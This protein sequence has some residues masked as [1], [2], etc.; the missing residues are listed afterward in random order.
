[1]ASRSFIQFTY[2][3]RIADGNRSANTLCNELSSIIGYLDIISPSVRA[4]AL[5]CTFS[6]LLNQRDFCILTRS[7]NMIK[8]AKYGFRFPETPS[9]KNL[10]TVVYNSY[11][12]DSQVRKCLESG[13]E[14][15]HYSGNHNEL[16]VHTVSYDKY[17]NYYICYKK[18][19]QALE[20][21]YN[22]ISVGG[23]YIE[24]RELRL[25]KNVHVPQCMHC[26][27]WDKHPTNRC[28]NR[29]YTKACSLCLG[30]HNFKQCRSYVNE[31]IKPIC[32][33]C[34][35]P[36]TAVSK[37]CRVAKE[38]ARNGKK[39]LTLRSSILQNKYNNRINMPDLA[40]Q[41][42]YYD[43]SSGQLVGYTP[44][45]YMSQK[46]NFSAKNPQM[47]QKPNNSYSQAVKSPKHNK[48]PAPL[49]TIPTPVTKPPQQ[50]SNDRQPNTNSK[51]VPTTDNTYSKPKY[52][53]KPLSGKLNSKIKLQQLVDRE[54]LSIQN[55][56]GDGDC[57]YHAICLLTNRPTNSGGILRKEFTKFLY[58]LPDKIKAEYAE[59]LLHN[60]DGP[61][62]ARYEKV[63]AF[64]ALVYQIIKGVY[65]GELVGSPVHG[66][67]P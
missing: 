30:Y 20:A 47:Q 40:N 15:K 45:P 35:G 5:G 51:L 48:K 34:K 18:P 1:M 16:N 9:N 37:G 33:N 31:N 8:L 28:P 59:H 21:A 23:F 26:Y 27:Q 29:H 22:G 43:P 44:H 7:N 24:S 50:K 17:S 38:A 52:V 62:G 65:A 2:S 54:N 10:C 66:Q 19:H 58:S 6:L 67:I 64:N 55:V 46:N 49:V 3:G 25:F 61:K 11:Y 36:H 41:A 32:R 42:K 57:F 53:F 60:Q 63:R 56:P 14:Y 12:S 4:T 13:L 39:D